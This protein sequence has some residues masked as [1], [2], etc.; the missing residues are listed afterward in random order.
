MTRGRVIP[1]IEESQLALV[2]KEPYGVVAAIVSWNYPIL[3]MAW[4][5]A[6]APGMVGATLAVALVPLDNV[7]FSGTFG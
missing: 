4:K 3:L 7:N 2:L 5:V 6:P 1:S